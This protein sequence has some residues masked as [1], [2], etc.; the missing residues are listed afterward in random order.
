MSGDIS[1][2]LLTTEGQDSDAGGPGL[3]IMTWG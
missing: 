3:I 1:N 2:S